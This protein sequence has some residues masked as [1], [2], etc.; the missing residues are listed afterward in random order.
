MTPTVQMGDGG[1]PERHVARAG[2]HPREGG[3]GPETSCVLR[4]GAL[5]APRPPHS[6]RVVARIGVTVH[7]HGRGEG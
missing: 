4:A 2:P 5:A 6:C 1:G 7:G 3:A